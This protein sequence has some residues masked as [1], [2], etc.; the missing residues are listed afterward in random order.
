M[1]TKHNPG[2]N[3]PEQN[4]KEPPGDRRKGE[5]AHNAEERTS[6]EEHTEGRDVPPAGSKRDPN[7]P[8]LGGG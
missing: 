4:T 2:A 8:W 3:M 7:S 1:H 5:K 6:D